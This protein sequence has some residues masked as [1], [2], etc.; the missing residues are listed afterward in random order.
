MTLPT[1][2]KNNE[3]KPNYS[4]NQATDMVG[5]TVQSVEVGVAESNP[6]LHERELLIITFT[7]GTKL[8]ISTGSNVQNVIMDLNR[9]G[10]VNI[11]PNDFHTD[12]DLTWQR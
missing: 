6:K 10:K 9:N 1:F 12:I 8:A 7:D 4:I 3:I 2:D 5:K 11:K